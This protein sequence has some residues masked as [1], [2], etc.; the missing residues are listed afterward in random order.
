MAVRTRVPKPKLTVE[1]VP[2]SSWYSN[3]RS[4]VSQEEWDRIR[5]KIYKNAS[6]VCEICGGEGPKWPVECHEVW[7]Y[8]ERTRVQKLERMIALC[9][10]CHEVKHI[11][12]ARIRG[13]MDAAIIHMVSVNKCSIKD[14]KEYI[15]NAFSIW[16]K[17]SQIDW[18]LD[19]TNLDSY[20]A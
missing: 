20:L 19:L 6:Y 8:N 10:S 9:P 1:L 15:S 14:A 2:A 3:V 7:K 5:K 12:L 11:G 18:E 13:R 17:R 16:D 4:N